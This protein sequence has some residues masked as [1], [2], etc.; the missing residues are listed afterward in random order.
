MAGPPPLEELFAAQPEVA[1]ERIVTIN[2]R[3]Q[4]RTR[5][6][7]RIVTVSGVPIAQFSESDRMAET[8]AAITLVEQGWADQKEVAAALNCSTR[9]LRRAQGRFRRGRACGARP[10]RRLPEG[11]STT[12][13]C[14]FA[15]R[16]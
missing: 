14:A 2:G 1:T 13:S 6:G 7:H 8:Y 15:A 3:C 9:T 4:V 11:A 16:Q 5:D 10:G 12:G